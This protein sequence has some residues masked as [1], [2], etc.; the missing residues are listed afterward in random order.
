MAQ[1]IEYVIGVIDRATAPLRRVMDAIGSVGQRGREATASTTSG[2]NTVA[3]AAEN[4]A[5]RVQNVGRSIERI[6]QSFQRISGGIASAGSSLGKIFSGNFLANIGTNLLGKL[7]S[8]F[9]SAGDAVVGGLFQKQKDI[10]GLETFLGKDGAADLYKQI[11]QDAAATPFGTEGLLEVNKALVSA[12]LGAKEARADTLALANAI[13]A[14]GGGN[15]E[16]SRMAANMQQIK[17]VG[18]ATAMDIKQFGM[19]GINIYQILADATGKSID[20]VKE[21]DVSYELLSKA[22]QKA[23]AEGGVYFGAMD[24]YSKTLPGMWDA[25]TEGLT[26]TATQLG[27]KFEPAIGAIMGL[28]VGVGDNIGGWLNKAQPVF[29]W[30]NEVILSITD[31]TNVWLGILDPIRGLFESIAPFL[32]WIFEGVAGILDGTSEWFEWLNMVGDLVGYILG[33]AGRIYESVFAIIMSAVEWVKQSELL[34][35]VF[36]AISTV[37]QWIA[38]LIG[39]LVEGLRVLWDNVI[40]PILDG[41]EKAYRWIKE[42]LGGTVEVAVTT[43]GGLP[44]ITTGSNDG[45]LKETVATQVSKATKADKSAKSGA[46]SAGKSGAKGVN[47]GGSRPTT[48]NITIHKLQD[49]IEIHATT[50]S[51]GGKR[52]ADEVANELVEALISLDGKK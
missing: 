25:F 9:S 41:I 17:T 28:I 31:G 20:Q 23:G 21:M 10:A 7:S 48:Y 3:S 5:G 14:V 36:S 16:L 39:K 47:S 15:A 18:V 33:V 45:K 49:K 42:M 4:V 22:L 30:I 44:T 38:N 2:L 40:R 52:A 37:V 6:P 1:G 19:T 35:D 8:M 27:E 24:R 46:A 50:T 11:Q 34:K 32:A 43:T 51:E 12:G 26:A 29:D 13:S